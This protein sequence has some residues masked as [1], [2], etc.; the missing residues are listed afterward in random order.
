M[1]TMRMMKVKMSLKMMMRM[2][3]VKRVMRMMGMFR[4]A[5]AAFEWA[6]LT[7]SLTPIPS[8]GIICSLIH[9]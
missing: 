6:F 2:T 3:K 5:W 1:G 9:T 7:R 8:H 4:L